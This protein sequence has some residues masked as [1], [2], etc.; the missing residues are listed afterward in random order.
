MI[1]HI[2]DKVIVFPG[3]SYRRNKYFTEYRGLSLFDTELPGLNDAL[4][5]IDEV[6]HPEQDLDRN[7]CVITRA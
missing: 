5:L 6:K 2:R 3:T 1:K 4:T 7:P